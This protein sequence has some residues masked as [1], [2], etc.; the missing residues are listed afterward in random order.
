MGKSVKNILWDLVEQV[1][2]ALNYEVV[3]VV[4]T[5]EGPQRVLRV[6]IDRPEGIGVEDCEAFSQ[7]LSTVLDEQDPISTA[8]LLEV[9]SPG[10]ERPLT[11]PEHFQRFVGQG[12]ELKLFAPV[13]GR[14]KLKGRL[15]GWS[16][17]AEGV[18]ILEMDGAI[19]DIPWKTISKARL[20]FID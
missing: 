12:V 17:Q 19:L 18:V 16:D 5:K 4:L 10:L 6:F 13:Q 7:Q 1:G 20:Q 14:K 11:K 15:K 8:Y 9:S 3:D 2:A